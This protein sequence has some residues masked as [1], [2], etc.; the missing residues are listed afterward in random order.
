ML[1]QNGV[2]AECPVSEETPVTFE[3]A[4]SFAQPTLET[5]PRTA[6]GP[7]EQ[8]LEA[9]RRRTMDIDHAIFERVALDRSEAAFSE[10]YDRFSYRVYALLL[11]MLRSEDD[12]QDL[13]QEI[14][15]II[16]NKSPEFYESRGNPAAWILT[17]TRNRAVD[18][19]RSKRYRKR[20][21]EKPFG[22][23]ADRQELASLIETRNTPDANLASKEAQSEIG[24]ALRVLNPE[25]RETIDL[26][27]FA[28]LSY[29]EIAERKGVPLS[30]VKSRVRQSV[31][32][33]A[34]VVKP[35]M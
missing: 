32:K 22:T 15:V 33:M 24:L 20:K 12:A 2:L 30:T 17:L 6:A 4:S 31:M 5:R 34:A 13:M 8:A 27:Y 14:F 19:M 3:R 9:R 29:S 7:S 10:L 25:Q 11:H 23:K 26:A 18:E 1:P 28:G 21:Y 35:R 16:W